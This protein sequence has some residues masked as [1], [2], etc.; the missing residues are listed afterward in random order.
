[1]V[2]FCSLLDFCHIEVCCYGA[3]AVVESPSVRTLPAFRS[4]FLV[5]FCIGVA[6]VAQHF[7]SSLIRDDFHFVLH[8]VRIFT[9]VMNGHGFMSVYIPDIKSQLQLNEMQ[10]SDVQLY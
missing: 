7:A 4:L 6:L 2:V 3:L 5:L 1:M 8:A 10:L 9:N